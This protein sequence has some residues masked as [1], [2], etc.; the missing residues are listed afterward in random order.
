MRKRLAGKAGQCE[1]EETKEKRGAGCPDDEIVHANYSVAKLAYQLMPDQKEWYDIAGGHFGLLYY[2]SELFD[3]A[4]R[5]QT[6][7]LKERL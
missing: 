2:P 4:T 5:V 3:E 7:F 6:E 1:K